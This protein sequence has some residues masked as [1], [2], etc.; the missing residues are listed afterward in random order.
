MICEFRVLEPSE[1]IG[2][3]LWYLV[4]GYALKCDPGAREREIDPF[5]SR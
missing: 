5:L 2:G 3:G 1:R 4:K